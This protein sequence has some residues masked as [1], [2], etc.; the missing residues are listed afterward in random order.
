[1]AWNDSKQAQDDFLSSDWNDMVTDQEARSKVSSGSGAPSSTPTMVGSM[2]IDTDSG[3]IYIAVGT[4]G[5]SDWKE[6]LS[7]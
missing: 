3:R 7:T 6:V 2:Y 1:M 5:S 4:S